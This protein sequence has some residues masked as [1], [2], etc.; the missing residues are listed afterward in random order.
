MSYAHPLTRTCN[1]FFTASTLSMITTHRFRVSVNVKTSP[2]SISDAPS[3][4]VS[5]KEGEMEVL[6]TVQTKRY[7]EEN[8]KAPMCGQSCY[9]PLFSLKP[10]L[11]YTW[12]ESKSLSGTSGTYGDTLIYHRYSTHIAHTHMYT[13]TTTRYESL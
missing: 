11:P 9:S 7:V 4:R 13:H 3:V 12:C 2:S 5:I 6:C 1:P 10:H 8:S